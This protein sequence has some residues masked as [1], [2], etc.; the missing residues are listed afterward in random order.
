LLP[1]GYENR[2]IAS[3]QQLLDAV[4]RVGLLAR[5]SSPVK[6]EFNALGVRLSSSSPDLGG[7]VEV[8]E[9]KYEGE[10]LTAAFNPQYLSDGLTG[11]VGERVVVEVRDGLKPA[12]VKGEGDGF[13]YLVMPVRLPAHVG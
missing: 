4:R 12:L 13:V 9:A 7:A 10:E 5:E 11:V 3:R 2:L 6:M 1:E 8:V